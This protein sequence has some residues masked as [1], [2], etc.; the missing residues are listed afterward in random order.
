VW[1]IMLID[2]LA[3]AVWL[4]WSFHRG[5]WQRSAGAAVPPP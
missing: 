5:H 4:L 3:R 1:A 2:H